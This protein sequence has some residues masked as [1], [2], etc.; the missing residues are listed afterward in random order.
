[1]ATEN[2]RSVYTVN[3]RLQAV[4]V[5]S[6]LERAGVPVAL[7][8]SISGAYIDVLVPENF[9]FDASNLLHPTPGAAEILSARAA[10]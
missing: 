7:K 9:V 3:G 6:V 2:Y 4:L 8:R 1:M 10:C 5:Q